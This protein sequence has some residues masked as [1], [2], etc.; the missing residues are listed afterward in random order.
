MFY[1]KK[2]F[3]LAVYFIDLLFIRVFFS[4]EC[5]IDIHASF[6]ENRIIKKQTKNKFGYLKLTFIMVH[7]YV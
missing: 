1:R 2:A 6:H 4:V 3:Q 5:L 7:F